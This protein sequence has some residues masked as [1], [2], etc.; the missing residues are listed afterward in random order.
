MGDTNR[1]N[2][3]LE[4]VMSITKEEVRE[5]AKKYLAQ[6]RRIIIDYLPESKKK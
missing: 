1:I 4:L 5:A 3:E 6:N 2:T